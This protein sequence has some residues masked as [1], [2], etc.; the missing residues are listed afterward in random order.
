MNK[1]RRLFA[2]Q[3][4]AVIGGGAWCEAI[5]GAARAIGFKGR[6]IPVHPTKTSIAG[7]PAVAQLSDIDGPIDA[8]FIGVNRRAT[9]EVVSELAAL[10]AGGGVC[11][12][13]GFSEAQGEDHDAGALQD[14]LVDAAGEMPVLG[15]N[16]YGLL[17]ALDRASV[18]P[19]QHG[20]RPVERGVALL[21]QSSNIA[22]N[23]TMQTRGLPVAMV[24]TCG[25]QAQTTQAEMA[26][27]LLDDPR[28]TALG[29]HVEGFG[30]LRAWEA[31][32]AKARARG[33]AILA[34][35]SGRSDQAQA[36]AVSHT[37]SL[38]GADAGAEAFMARLGI[39]R[40]HSL[41]AFVE[42]L[43]IAHLY[44][45]LPGRRVGSISCSGGEA[46]LAADTGHGALEF[47]TL[48]SPQREALRAALGPMV[49]LANPLDYH[50]YIWRDE[51]AM[52]RAWAAMADPVLDLVMI[53]L[54]YPRLDRCDPADWAIAT[55]AA[56]A[57]Q[58]ETGQRY[59]V[60]ATLPELLP[61]PAAEELLAAGVLPLC[62]LDHA[63]EAIGAMGTPEPP[64]APPVALP[65]PDR[66]AEL[67]TES[68]AK[69]ALAAHGVQVPSG[70]EATLDTAADV[71]A[72]LNGPV[73]VKA[74]GLA[75]KTEAG[76]IALNIADRA[77]LDAAL[78]RLPKGPL[79]IEEMVEGVVAELLVGVTRDPAHGFLLTLGAG[80]T[81][82][83]LLEDRVTLLL[84]APRAAVAEALSQLRLAPVLRGYR[85]AAPVDLDALL[86]AIAAIEAYVLDNQA[87]V[88]EVEVN[89]LLCTPSAAIAADAL[90]RKAPP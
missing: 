86:D 67:L 8:A 23:L 72:T 83:E 46:A 15:P 76:G 5:L 59:A 81:L 42:A 52:T 44:G 43:K 2:P 29:L 61:E 19:D 77:G 26:T 49:S 10:N 24:V 66:D 1:F 87:T 9:I 65:G 34:L 48:T 30:D 18:W 12:A 58:R 33:V 17:N 40:L 70:A 41:P 21:T 60:V 14:A 56:I 47:P 71:A 89:P 11:F 54:D 64:M 7:Q 53:I 50:T 90:I 63:V 25:N 51:G 3:S 27:A 57:A 31:L 80:G 20:L 38:S 37:A 32:A 69:A 35:K 68:A 16:C 82:T 39:L 36:A 28:I 88:E 45:R 74:L 79:W 55:R 6:I 4:I 13:S 84:H 78:R 62:G 73:A 75:H 22:I 85:G